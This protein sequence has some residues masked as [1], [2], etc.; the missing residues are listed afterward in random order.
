LS[1]PNKINENS[2]SNYENSGLNGKKIQQFR[3]K[4][5][6]LQAEAEDEDET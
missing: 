4:M 6:A 5:N 1:S 3:L 2:Q